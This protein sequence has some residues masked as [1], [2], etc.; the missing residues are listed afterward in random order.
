MG[1]AL[2]AKSLLMLFNCIFFLVGGALLAV[3]FYILFSPY[4]FDILSVLDNGI[5]QA[6]VYAIIAIGA[7]VF[8]LAALGLFGACCKSKILLGLYLIILFVIIAAQVAVCAVVYA[9]SGQVNAFVTSQLQETLDDY[10]AE[11]GTD[12]YSVGWNSMQ[13]FFECCGTN[14][15]TDWASTTWGGDSSIFKYESG[16]A[17]PITCCAVQDTTVV[18]SGSINEAAFTDVAK[19]YGD[20]ESVPNSYMAGTG[21]GCYDS[22]QDYIISNSVLIGGVG[23]GLAAFEILLF[24]FALIVCF[25][26]EKDEDVV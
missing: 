4:S 1:F 2:V 15:Y 25:T 21:E 22:F 16:A 24:I 13:I 5:I 14:N 18:L 8:I 10:E 7:F 26:M 17:Y 20:G 3:G 6:G 23:I 9:Y 12:S 11:N 19:C